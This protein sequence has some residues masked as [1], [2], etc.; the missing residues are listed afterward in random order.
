MGQTPDK[1][2]S[3]ERKVNLRNKIMASAQK[4]K[5]LRLLQKKR[6]YYWAAAA[7]IPILLTLGYFSMQSK[8][9]PSIDQ[10]VKEM[11]LELPQNTDKVTVIL[12]EGNQ[13]ALDEDEGRVEYSETGSNIQ[14][15]NGKQIKQNVDNPDNP[16]FNTVMVP[17]GKR[18]YIKLSDGTK[19]W[20]NSG[21]KLI[22]PAVFEDESREVY[23]E[24][25]AIFEVTHNKERPFRVKSGTQSI[26]VLG[27]VF[28]VSHYSEDDLMQTVLKS[29]SIRI[30]YKD[31]KKG[32]LIQPGTLS[33]FNQRSNTI[34]TYQV[35]PDDYFSWRDGFL[36]LDNNSL[37]D[38]ASRLSRYYNKPVFLDSNKLADQTFSGRLDLSEDMVD[39]LH[40]IKETTDFEIIENQESI[41]LKRIT[42]KNRMPMKK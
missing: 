17:Y 29:G 9:K 5:E 11:P 7:V 39:V 21:S 12:G 30:R 27:T 41:L 40:I 34:N 8:E 3:S 20:I 10:F 16:I 24:G 33:S 1:G 26:E 42:T 22:F 2:W 14:M 19:V 28:N 23:L 25:E 18:S 32:I 15:G 6:R 37:G 13:V 31:N 38:I 35:D 4:E 36:T